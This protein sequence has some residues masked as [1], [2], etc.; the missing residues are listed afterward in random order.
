MQLCSGILGGE[1]PVDDRLGLIALPLQ[2]MDVLAETILV[3]E[4]SAQDMCVI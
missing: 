3:R 4:A 1:A 2:G